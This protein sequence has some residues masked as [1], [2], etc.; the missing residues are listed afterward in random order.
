MRFRAVKAIHSDF[1]A[2][3]VVIS[4]E[5]KNYYVTGDTLYNRA[6]LQGL[7]ELEAIFLPIN[8]VGNNM[9]AADAARLAVESGAK[10]KVPLHVG[11]MDSLRAEDIF[12]VPGRVIPRFYEEIVLG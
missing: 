2:I 8:G 3:G 6:L 4:A 1:D 5:G 10:Y 7:P 12:D 11:L 9:N